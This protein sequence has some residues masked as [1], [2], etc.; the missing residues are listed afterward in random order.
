M[1]NRDLPI[2]SS[3]SAYLNVISLLVAQFACFIH[4][5]SLFYCSLSP[6]PHPLPYAFL[7]QKAVGGHLRNE[8]EICAISVANAVTTTGEE[9]PRAKG[10]PISEPPG[11]FSHATKGKWPF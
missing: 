1:S 4:S 6:L 8:N 3:R 9:T 11:E 7:R 5:C 10:T 2:V